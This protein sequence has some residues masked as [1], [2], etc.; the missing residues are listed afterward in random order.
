MAELGTCDYMVSH[1]NQI[2]D[3]PTGAGKTYLAYALS[4]AALERCY[5]ARYVR[6]SDQVQS[7]EECLVLKKS[8]R[9]QKNKYSRPTLLVIEEWQEKQG[10]IL[11]LKRLLIELFRTV[12][13]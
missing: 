5:R 13:R 8:T 6:R 11:K 10:E 9:K 7:V 3:D 1:T 4:N 2:T 12:I